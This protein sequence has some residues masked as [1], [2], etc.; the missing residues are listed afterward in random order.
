[1]T[2]V[3]KKAWLLLLCISA[4]SAFSPRVSPPNSDARDSNVDSAMAQYEAALKSMSN[5]IAYKEVDT[6]GPSH[7]D[8]IFLQHMNDQYEAMEKYEAALKAALQST[9]SESMMRAAAASVQRTSNTSKA[10]FNQQESQGNPPQ[11]WHTLTQEIHVII[12]EKESMANNP[13]TGEE[14]EEI[15]A[16]AITGSVLGAAI[17]SPLL[18]GAVLGYTGTQILKGEKGS[19]TFEVLGKAK[20]DF[21]TKF[22]T[23]V[24]AAATFTR[25]QWKEDQDLSR[26]TKKILKAMEENVHTVPRDFHEAP[27]QLV[28]NVK[29]SVD[30]DGFQHLRSRTLNA[31]RDF[32]GSKEF[33]K[34]S[35]IA[36]QVIQKGMESQEMKAF[37]T[38]ASNIVKDTTQHQ[39][40]R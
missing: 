22:A 38:R 1:M 28:E 7:R 2:K 29:R 34:L 3:S 12:S 26:V 19:K 18:V 14:I 6:Y 8:P 39:K 24:Q 31:L 27:T 37:Q 5:S 30:S 35:N 32:M 4:S 10:T 9:T 20:H 17:G 33:Q 23:Q 25:E 21:V 16:T 36:V 13:L 40:D 11:S 15:V